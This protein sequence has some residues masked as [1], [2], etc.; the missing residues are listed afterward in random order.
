VSLYDSLGVRSVLNAAA[1]QTLLGGA[2]MPEPVLAA[3]RDAAGAAVHLPELH[4]RVG[5]RIATLT[6]NEAA[7]LSC[8]AAAGILVAVAACMTRDDL[9]KVTDLPD[10]SDLP[11]TEVITFRAHRNGFLSAARESGATLVEVGADPN[12]LRRAIS[13]RTAA[14]LWFAGDFWEEAALPLAPTIA[15]SRERDVPVIVDAADQIP[16]VSTLWSFTRDEGA[17]LAI[18]SGGK[19]LRGP[20]ASGII[21]GRADLIRACRANSGP[22]ESI[23]RPAKVG[24]EEM[25][26]LLAAVEW[27]LSLDEAET[28]ERYERIVADWITGLSALPGIA[29]ARSTRSHSGQPIPR[30]IVTFESGSRRDDV[31]AFLWELDPRIAVLPEGK[32]AIGLNPQLLDAEEAKLVGEAIRQAVLHIRQSAPSHV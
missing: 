10:T 25:L 3:M 21:L 15:I 30:A 28:A 12:E 20:Q 6:H 32:S 23:G 27:T 31:V 29:V 13:E 22:L 16:P 4:D 5:E 7:C 26:G 11:R 18:F 1:A 19:G 17:D 24:K 9:S 2:L 14:V 8:G